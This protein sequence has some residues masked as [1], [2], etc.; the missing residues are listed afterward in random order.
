M[1]VGILGG[2]AHGDDGED[3]G[4]VVVGVSRRKH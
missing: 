3:V 4:G 1:T 2:G